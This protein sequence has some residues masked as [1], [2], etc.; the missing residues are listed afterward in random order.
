MSAVKSKV[1]QLCQNFDA[2]EKSIDLSDQNP[3]VV[4]NVLKLYLRKVGPFSFVIVLN[5]FS[6]IYLNI[7]F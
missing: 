4:A 1:E 7:M 3:N 6:I 2:D 5:I